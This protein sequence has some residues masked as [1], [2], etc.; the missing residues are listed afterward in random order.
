[1]YILCII[2]KSGIA[3]ELLFVETV[4]AKFLPHGVQKAMVSML[5]MLTCTPV[6]CPL[7]SAP[8]SYPC[9]NSRECEGRGRVLQ[10]GRSLTDRFHLVVN[11]NKI[12]K[13]CYLHFASIH[14]NASENEGYMLLTIVL[15]CAV[16][17]E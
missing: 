3:F 12:L 17:N 9:P 13:F 1:M 10:R 14:D 11:V 2:S 4:A 7:M 5:R 8:L 15:E 16:E 6:A